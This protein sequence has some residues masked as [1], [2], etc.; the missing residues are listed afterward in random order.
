MR[1]TLSATVAYWN[2]RSKACFLPSV[3]QEDIANISKQI[4]RSF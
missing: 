1:G 3:L 2:G 4:L